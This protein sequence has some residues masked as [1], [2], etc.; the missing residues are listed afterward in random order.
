[1]IKFFFFYCISL[2]LDTSL[3]GDKV[4]LSPS[5]SYHFSNPEL[6]EV[7]LKNKPNFFI[8]LKEGLLNYNIQKERKKHFI[9]TK[10]QMRFFQKTNPLISKTLLTWGMEDKN[11]II[12]GQAISDT[13]YNY[14]F[15]EC[16][17]SKG[18]IVL[19]LKTP[20]PSQEIHPCLGYLNLKPKIQAHLMLINH[21]RMKDQSVGLGAPSA[22]PWTL[23]PEGQLQLQEVFG[24][25]QSS[26]S[27][28]KSKGEMTFEGLLS[29]N[30]PLRFT[31][32]LE[33]GIQPRSILA[34]SSIEWK[35]I[36]SHIF[37][38]LLDLDE[39]QALIEVDFKKM[40]RTGQTNVFKKESFKRKNQLNLNQWVKL[41]TYIETTEDHQR[42][43]PLS[44]FLFGK[45][46]R[47][48]LSQK[49]ELWLKLINME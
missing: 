9:L 36:T 20:N 49:K 26:K 24:E 3:V 14:L 46:S 8:G 28:D 44:F 11:L 25:I 7:H 43:S 17:K 2:A 35:N 39:K 18:R 42:R 33:I 31:N 34:R 47:S 37:L 1:M 30:Q 13:L 19:D 23:T 41:L 48:Q 32:G 22:L 40:S 10:E 21:A 29:L 15:A 38:D 16:K 27:Q 45:K 6:I 12:K 4:T 5:S